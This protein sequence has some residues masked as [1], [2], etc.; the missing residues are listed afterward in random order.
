VG[1]NFLAAAAMK[2]TLSLLY[3]KSGQYV[4]ASNTDVRKTWAKY[5]REQ[6]QQRAIA[7]EQAKVVTP[8]KRR[9]T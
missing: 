6:A 8:I 2:P 4:P 1:D 7:A 5:R 3:W 9:G